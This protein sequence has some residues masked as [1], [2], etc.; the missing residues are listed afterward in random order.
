MATRIYKNYTRKRIKHVKRS[1]NGELQRWQW[2]E[3]TAT[4]SCEPATECE[5]LHN[6]GRPEWNGGKMVKV[7]ERYRATIWF[8]GLADPSIKKDGLII[9]G[10]Q[11]IADL[12]DT[13]HVPDLPLEE[14]EDVYSQLIRK[15]D[16]HFLL[17][18]N[19]DYTR[20]KFGNLRSKQTIIWHNIMREFGRSLKNANSQTRMKRCETTW[21]RNHSH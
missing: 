4:N 20:F 9:Y 6:F 8:F 19:K 18:K 12:E 16:K 10:G 11:H 3:Y 17:R 2:R 7:E 21:L 13:I 14:D 15:L 5:T 1:E